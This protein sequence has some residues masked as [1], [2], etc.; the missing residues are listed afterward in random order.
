MVRRLEEVA[1]VADGATDLAEIAA[2]RSATWWLLSRLVCEAPE[3]PWLGEL[4]AALAAAELD[5]DAALQPE[6]AALL[7]AL[8]AARAQDDGLVALAV[9]RTRLLGGV[10]RDEAI[11]APYETVAMGDEMNASRVMA[12]A[13]AYAEA[14]FSDRAGQ[15]GPP[16]ALGAELR[17]MS[18]LCFREMEARRDGDPASVASWLTRQQSFMDEHVLCWV[19]A[20]C[21]RIALQA[22]TPFY[23]AAAKLLAHACRIDRDDIALLLEPT[24]TTGPTEPA[25]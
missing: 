1:E 11:P 9:D 21:D 3:A 22:G 19:P 2:R 24:T 20:H 10:I 17:F 18:L 16:D 12:V 6:S 25:A 23:A 4:E 8:H 5:P 15:F 13:D 7:E 14:G